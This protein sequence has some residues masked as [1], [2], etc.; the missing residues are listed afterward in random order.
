MVSSLTP[1]WTFIYISILA[2][3][4]QPISKTFCLVSLV[5]SLLGS[6][7][8]PPQCSMF[9]AGPPSSSLLHLLPSTKLPHLPV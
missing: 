9:D 1:S 8:N 4:T 7:Q 6:Y 5:N 2:V 3:T